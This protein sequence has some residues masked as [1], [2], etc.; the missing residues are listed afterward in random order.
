M[1]A[2]DQTPIYHV[3]LVGAG[4]V[5]SSWAAVFA[6][7]GLQVV[8]YD[9]DS[10]ARAQLES[11]VFHA[12]ESLHGAGLAAE[13]VASMCARV[14]LATSLAEALDGAGYVQE[15]IA[16]SLPAKRALFLQLDAVAS[17]GAILASSTSSFPMSAIAAALH[18]RRRCVVVHP[19]NPPHLVPFTEVC[20]APFTADTIV[21]AAM[22]LMR[23]VGQSPVH[24]RRE[25][26]GFVLNRLQW[27]LLAEACRLVEE[28][29]VDPADVDA[30]I[31]EGL[32]RRW[33]FLG[34]FEV[35]E[36][37]APGGLRD[38]LTRFG[39]TIDAINGSRGA[40]TPVAS[41]AAAERLHAQMPRTVDRATR[42][43]ER[44]QN[45]LAIARLRGRTRFDA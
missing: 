32:G 7:A 40:P 34:P 28:G 24:V 23:R 12:L 14:R 44:D 15:S 43:A 3:A 39:P 10:G 25:V 36:L 45:L 8:A 35:G 9:E 26:E 13:P 42:L 21:Q 41:A 11:R 16:E 4:L 37:N 19:V 17:P 22:E 27:T 18:G 5:G 20:G 33:A 2:Q 38:Y 29:V 30:A 1:H 31:R 6:R